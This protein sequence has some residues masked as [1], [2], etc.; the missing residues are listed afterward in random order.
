MPTREMHAEFPDEACAWQV[1]GESGA[2]WVLDQMQQATP[3]VLGGDIA[4]VKRNYSP[5]IMNQFSD[6][7]RSGQHILS[8]QVPN[9]QI[10]TRKLYC[11]YYYPNPKDLII[12]YMDPLGHICSSCHSSPAAFLPASSRSFFSMLSIMSSETKWLYADCAM[13]M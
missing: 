7:H 9:N 10:L 8:V 5:D 11:N 12:G 1:C 2:I 4:F 13:T 6:E 3:V